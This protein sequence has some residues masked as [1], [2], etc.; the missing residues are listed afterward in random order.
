MDIL[1]GLLISLWIF[2][3]AIFVARQEIS[4]EGLFG[5]Q[6]VTFTK[7]YAAN[8]LVSRFFRAIA[9]KDKWA[10][11]YHLNANGGW[12]FIYFGWLFILP[13]LWQEGFGFDRLVNPIVLALWA[14]LAY[15]C[16]EDFLWFT[17]NPWY[18]LDRFNPDYIPWHQEWT[19]GLPSG[20][21]KTVF[22]SFMLILAVM[23]QTGDLRL[24]VIWVTSITFTLLFCWIMALVTKNRPRQIIFP[25][26]WRV[27]NAVAIHRCHYPVEN[28][29][30]QEP[31]QVKVL[32]TTAEEGSRWMTLKEYMDIYSALPTGDD[33]GSL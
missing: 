23:T 20:Y 9:G 4:V 30:S 24:L 21:V 19:W 26:W 13:F 32:A 22:I 3:P 12:L 28:G 10:T 7:R 5:W 16:V 1:N 8:T 2:L 6:A 29:W 18:G 27:I 14:F 25:H 17:L 33:D 31:S 11:S 15:L